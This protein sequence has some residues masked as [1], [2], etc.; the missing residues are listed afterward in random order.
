LKPSLDLLILGRILLLQDALHSAPDNQRLGELVCSA[1]I[2]I[3]GVDSTAIYM[4]ERLVSRAS[5]SSEPTD[6]PAFWQDAER[7]MSADPEIFVTLPLQ[8]NN[9]NYGFLALQLSDSHKFQ[10]YLPHLKNTVNLIALIL[11]NRQQAAELRE[12][13]RNLENQVREGDESL[14]RSEERLSL[15]QQAAKSGIWDWNLQT[16]ALFFDDYYFR[17]GGYEPNEFSSSFAE[18]KKRVHPDDI[19]QAEE[20]I[21]AC[22]AGRSQQFAVEFRFKTKS[23]GWLW[24]LG[25]GII[26]E[27]DASGAPLR[28][29]GTH[30]D[31]DERKQA[32]EALRRSEENLRTT[33][34]SIGDAVIATDAETRVTRMNPVAEKLT[35]W[36]AAEAKGQLLEMVFC[37][38]NVEDRKP[39]KNTARHVLQRS[40]VVTLGG[41]T[42]LIAKNGSEH[43]IADSGAPIRNSANEMVGVVLVFRDVTQEK[44]LQTQLLQIQKMDTIGQLAGGIAHDFNNMLGGIIGAAE[45]LKRRLPEDPKTGKFIGMILDSAGRAAALTSKLLVFARK[46]HVSSTPVDV[47][48]ALGNTV[49]LLENTIDRRVLIKSELGA[50]A[51]T[52]L[53][54]LGQLQNAFLNLGINAA[55][56]MPEGGELSISTQ[57]VVVD[58]IF[59]DLSNFELQPGPY[60]EIV[61]RDSGHGIPV[62]NLERIFEPFF[63]TKERGKGTG[64]GLAAVFGT[65]Q[66]HHGS[67]T[68]YSEVG[69]GSAFSIMLPLTDVLPEAIDTAAQLQLQT[70][71]GLILVVDDEPVMRATSEMILNDL[72][73]EVL[74]AENGRVGLELFRKRQ[75]EIN[76]VLLDMIMP[77]MNGQECFHCMRKIDPAARIVLSSGFT[78]IDDLKV[79]REAGLV[80]FIRKP[81]RSVAL[82]RIV[83]AALSD[84]EKEATLWGG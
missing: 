67:I 80:G 72:G 50:E 30:T 65:V 22:L 53:G 37:I 59:C 1:L 32:D 66:M 52:V 6:W 71:T 19:A 39:V 84:D 21:E 74:L 61:F 4:A 78:R 15:A 14:Q 29:T 42:L 62:R 25:Q 34:D 36:S 70:G 27:R 12:L 35:G 83:A 82:S 79:L 20:K 69:T 46:Q 57:D 38:L 26:S 23:G 41:N 7:S 2:D 77:E 55:Q 48:L 33:L 81:Y 68:A 31:I 51:S 76:L 13:N 24:I 40:E 60:L 5:D 75:S 9:E 56:A 11:E 16:G 44:A 54:D 28:F 64:L 73:Y 49:S 43:L 3:P 45:L 18:W 58:K 8:I 17:Q 10:G 63:T 47:H